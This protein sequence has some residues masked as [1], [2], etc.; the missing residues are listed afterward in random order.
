M[1]KEISAYKK[2]KSVKSLKYMDE[3]FFPTNDFSQLESCQLYMTAN[4]K[5]SNCCK[6]ETVIQRYYIKNVLLKIFQ[7]SQENLCARV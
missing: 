5:P 1:K 4:Y 3:V 2:S 6:I 7:N